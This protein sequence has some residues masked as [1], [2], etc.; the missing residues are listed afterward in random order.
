MKNV[1]V[2]PWIGKLYGKN[3]YFKNKVMILGESH[4]CD[5]CGGDCSAT[6]ENKCDSRKDIIE[7]YLRYKKGNG[8]FEHWFN[9]YTKFTNLFIGKKCDNETTILFWNS[10]LFYNYVQKPVTKTRESPTSEMFI[11]NTEAFFEIIKK[12]NPDAIFA[13]GKRLWGKMPSDKYFDGI[14]ILGR[15]SGFYDIGINKIPVF[16]IDHPSTGLDYNWTKKY[17]K[18]AMNIIKQ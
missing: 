16:F 9:T 14:T 10:I 6:I 15:T 5:G 7:R 12:F 4:Y 13:W 17:L 2:N 18:K 11:S 8:D 1:I 3:G